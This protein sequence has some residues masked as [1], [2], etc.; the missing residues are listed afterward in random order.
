MND[1][2]LKLM[3]RKDL[4]KARSKERFEEFLKDQNGMSMPEI[5]SMVVA[6]TVGLALLIKFWG[7]WEP[8]TGISGVLANIITRIWPT[9][10]NP[11]QLAN[12]PN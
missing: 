2:L 1:L 8:P 5:I 4:M 9:G 7:T 6:A 10:A 11:D 12:P 3:V